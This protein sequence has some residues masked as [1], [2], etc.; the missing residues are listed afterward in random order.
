[1]SSH[2]TAGQ[3]HNMKT[4]NKSFETVATFKYLSTT[5]TNHIYN[6]TDEIRGSS[7]HRQ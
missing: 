3:N 1:M 4:V 2:Q 5:A 7:L 6:E